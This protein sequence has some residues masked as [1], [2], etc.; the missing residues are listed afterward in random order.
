MDFKQNSHEK[1]NIRIKRPSDAGSFPASEGR[2]LLLRV[3]SFSCRHRRAAYYLSFSRVL[4][5]FQLSSAISSKSR[6]SLYVSRL[7][8]VP[9]GI[10]ITVL[11]FK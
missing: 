9:Y 4:R 7:F 5:F 1:Y 11:F 2:I 3:C 6:T 10:V 8:D